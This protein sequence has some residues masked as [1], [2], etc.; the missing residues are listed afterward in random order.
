[1]IEFI[2]ALL[3]KPKLAADLVEVVRRSFVG[4]RT[5]ARSSTELKSGF[6]RAIAEP[7]RAM[8]M[9]VKE[10]RILIEVCWITFE[11]YERGSSCSCACCLNLTRNF[12]ATVKHFILV[13]VLVL[14]HWTR[15]SRFAATASCLRVVVRPTSSVSSALLHHG[16]PHADLLGSES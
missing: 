7:S 16:H 6:G 15:S 10:K 4:V 9:V 13:A 8:A 5:A 1:M 2:A 14:L 3:Q 12:K 11:R